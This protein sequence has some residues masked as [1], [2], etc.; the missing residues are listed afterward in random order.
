M[1][2]PIRC[3]SCGKVVS[4]VWNEYQKMLED[5]VSIKEALDKLEIKR[6]CCRSTLM[7]HVEMINSVGKFV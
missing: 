5:D 3:F 6:F 4:A 2:V 1:I 7:S